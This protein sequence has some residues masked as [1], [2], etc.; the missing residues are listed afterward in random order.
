MKIKLSP[1]ATDNIA[2]QILYKAYEKVCNNLE[3]IYYKGFAAQESYDDLLRYKKALDI[4]L[5]YFVP[6]W[7]AEK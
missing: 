2:G 6:N 3:A 5:E 4:A 7:E 1:E